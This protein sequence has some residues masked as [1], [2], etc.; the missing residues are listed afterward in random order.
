MPNP[1]PWIAT[2]G[3][4]VLGVAL[5]RRARVALQLDPI[6]GER[7]LAGAPGLITIRRDRWGTP[8][9]R[10]DSLAGALYG[11]GFVTAEDRLFQLDLSRRAA[12]GALA[13]VF[14]ERAFPADQLLRAIGFL[15]SAEREWAR[16]SPAD[17]AL[18]EAYCA[19]LNAG[20]AALPPPIETRL[21]RYR[22]RPFT[23]EEIIAFFKLMAWSLALNWDSELARL[24]LADVTDAT[25]VQ[26]LDPAL[27]SP[28]GLG[29][30]RPPLAAFA[31]P[32]PAA[33]NAFAIAGARAATGAPLLASDPHLRSGLPPVFSFVHLTGGELDVIGAS[34][35][36]IPG[37]LIGHNRRI[38][39]GLTIAVAD[40][41]D[42]FIE[43]VDPNDPLRYFHDGQWKRMATYRER[44]VIRGAAPREEVIRETTHGPVISSAFA[45]DT[46]TLTLCGVPL[47]PWPG[48]ALAAVRLNRA[49]NWDEFRAAVADLAY[50][51]LNFVYADV[52]GHIGYHFG[53]RAPIR[54][55]G[56]GALP[57][58]GDGSADWI[59]WVPW[60]QTPF[61]F[62]PPNGQVVSANDRPPGDDQPGAPFFGFEWFEPYRARRLA[63]LLAQSDR[64]TIDSF[65]RIQRDVAS[66]PMQSL[67]TALLA[68]RPRRAVEAVALDSLRQWDGA[69]RADSAAAA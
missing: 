31:L 54:R 40:T 33:S 18:L 44:F 34:I 43:R 14:G 24:F 22:V 48:S 28:N 50:P 25:T 65:R 4:A 6:Q 8:H 53:G 62:D 10:A 58:P 56:V 45:G 49:A 36:G 41:Q 69:M 55:S 52:D 35:P 9:V 23:P 66:A 46:R 51:T 39:W 61:L 63:A 2:A 3:L 5:T 37:V 17:R 57:A 68:L 1:L 15:R 11:Q 32:G 19:G 59:G 20:L 16:T 42:V 60:E 26:A 7:R 13:E 12:T 30:T 27:E 38:A 47:Q 29:W 67:A 64:H 21:L